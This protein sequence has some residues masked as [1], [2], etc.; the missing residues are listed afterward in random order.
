M[1]TLLLDTAGHSI[2]TGQGLSLIFKCFGHHPCRVYMVAVE[3]GIVFLC[4][5][6][7]W[8]EKEPMA[9]RPLL[10]TDAPCLAVRKV[11]VLPGLDVLPA[12]DVK[13][14]DGE[15]VVHPQLPQRLSG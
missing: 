12:S 15:S 6:S 7:V 3:V 5:S 9:L 1:K 13:S 8:R 11:H 2:T 10:G 4:L 14:V